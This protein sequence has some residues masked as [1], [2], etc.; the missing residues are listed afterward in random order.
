[1]VSMTG[2]ALGQCIPFRFEAKKSNDQQIIDVGAEVI[3][4][5]LST[6]EARK[7]SQLEGSQIRW[8]VPGKVFVI[9]CLKNND[10]R[11]KILKKT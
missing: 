6:I 7:S 4:D 10:S 2:E 3:V 8:I 11:K 5:R 9:L 1:M